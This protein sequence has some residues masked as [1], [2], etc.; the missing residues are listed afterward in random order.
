MCSP[1]DIENNKIKT[2]S[3]ATALTK[4]KEN[5]TSPVITTDE[6]VSVSKFPGALIFDVDDT[7]LV[8]GES[9]AKK[10]T[11]IKNESKVIRVIK[12]AKEKYYF[13]GIVSARDNALEQRNINHFPYLSVETVCKKLEIECKHA[14]AIGLK[15]QKATFM[16]ALR[17]EFFP[18]LDNKRIC[19]V[20]DQAFFMSSA[21]SRGFSTVSID[22]QDP[23]AEIEEFLNGEKVNYLD[24]LPDELSSESSMQNDAITKSSNP[25]C[26]DMMKIK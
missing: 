8:F 26:S 20:D 2:S 5:L 21:S 18:H 22:S 24:Q 4:L 3:T 13:I 19:L 16:E 25:A 9:K 12:L 14:Y 10:R 7:L 6:K 17:D 15:V 1:R 23:F 11:I